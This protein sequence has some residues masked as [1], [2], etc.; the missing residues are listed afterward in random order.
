MTE[1]TQVDMTAGISATRSGLIAS[2]IDRA[3]L[4]E[5]RI[6]WALYMQ[7]GVLPKIV[8]KRWRG[9]GKLTGGDIGVAD[10]KSPMFR[11]GSKL[12][13][14]KVLVT[15]RFYDD[16]APDRTYAQLLDSVEK[17][18]RMRLDGLTFATAFGQFLPVK[19]FSEWRTLFAAYKEQAYAIVAEMSAAWDD[20]KA[21]TLL[22]YA[23]EA[24]EAFERH[25][26]LN[27]DHK[28][29][30]SVFIDDYLR[31]IESAL[32]SVEDFASTFKF[33]DEYEFIPLPA[34]IAEDLARA[35]ELALE[36]EGK[37]AEAEEL[38]A[39]RL[40]KQSE[41]DALEAEIEAMKAEVLGKVKKD[42]Q[43]QAN[44]FVDG[45][46]AQMRQMI[47]TVAS[48]VQKSMSANGRMASKS[49]T[50]VKNMISKVRTMNFMDDEQ[51]SAMLDELESKVAGSDTAPLERTLAEVSEW[52]AVQV[53]EISRVGRS[54]L[55]VD[56][57]EAQIEV[58]EPVRTGRRAAAVVEE[59]ATEETTTVRRSR[60]A[61]IE[62]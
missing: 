15:S 43:D 23:D 11:L 41:N 28:A 27:A 46:M 24:A 55:G 14:P 32:P 19:N 57:A 30:M 9:R 35:E 50:Q 44:N 53:D 54:G 16:K 8:S 59:I 6:N 62:A 13:L 58:V 4:R 38:R 17:S 21:A 2:G 33:D 60:R 56:D 29:D 26:L 10:L 40:A 39:Q 1:Q 7:A 18:A 34:M 5:K 3:K 49:K 31:E 51:V 12:L 48:D 52:C 47:M 42:A 45:I 22:E 37:G 36:A 25:N 61:A 20:I